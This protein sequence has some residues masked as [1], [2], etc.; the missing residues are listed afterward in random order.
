MYL[1]SVVVRCRRPSPV[2]RRP[3]SSSVIVR[4]YNKYEIWFAYSL[5]LYAARRDRLH[6]Y[7]TWREKKK[8]K[9]FVYCSDWDATRKGF[10][11]FSFLKTN[12]ISAANP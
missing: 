7:G 9:M 4:A 3:S 5:R 1:S 10:R 2:V 6:V 11:C 12:R 8:N